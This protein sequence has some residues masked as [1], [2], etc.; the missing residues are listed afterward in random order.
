[1]TET[2]PQA[3]DPSEPL[4]EEV[5]A[6]PPSHGAQHGP[7]LSEGV[8]QLLLERSAGR[9]SEEELAD[10]LQAKLDEHRANVEGAPPMSWA[11]RKR[12]APFRP[13][14]AGRIVEVLVVLALLAI[15][16]LALQVVA[17]GWR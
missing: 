6:R 1:M 10:A 2:E 13:S 11:A 12:A 3:P 17:A 8:A 16:C 9:L 7:L 4:H 14:V 15:G 5:P